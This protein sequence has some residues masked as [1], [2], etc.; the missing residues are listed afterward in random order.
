MGT[1]ADILYLTIDGY[2]CKKTPTENG[3]TQADVEIPSGI[4]SQ[5]YASQIEVTLSESVKRLT[6]AHLKRHFNRKVTEDRE[7]DRG[8]G[9]KREERG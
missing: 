9:E 8:G 1:R 7:R 5:T 2:T 3:R 4:S 6:K